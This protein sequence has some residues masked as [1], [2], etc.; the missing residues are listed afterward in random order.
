MRTDR[1]LV[2]AFVVSLMKQA[3][4]V[5]TRELRIW[6]LSQS[7]VRKVVVTLCCLLL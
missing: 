7:Q 1:F 4:R 5:S 3:S 2:E 6:D